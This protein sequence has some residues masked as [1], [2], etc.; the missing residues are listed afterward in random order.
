MTPPYLES[1]LWIGYIFDNVRVYFRGAAWQLTEKIS[2]AADEYVLPCEARAVYNATQVEG[3]SIG[4]KAIV[5]IRM[6]IPSRLHPDITLEELR[7]YKCPNGLSKYTVQEVNNVCHLSNAG[8]KSSPKLLDWF[9]DTQREGM[10][11]PGSYIVFI[12][13]EKLPGIIPWE[14]WRMPIE[15]RDGIREAFDK[16]I[17]YKALMIFIHEIN[18]D[19]REVYSHGIES[20]DAG[21]KNLLWDERNN[22]CYILDYEDCRVVNFKESIIADD[23]AM[24]RIRLRWEL[25]QRDGYRKPIL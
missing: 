12:L 22:K 17:K 10:P 7:E 14:F 24:S 20:N 6:E 19:C 2:E 11:F 25:E 4:E 21:I 15:K 8:C 13:M 16:A 3:P 18:E 23:E 9:V 1:H 5:K